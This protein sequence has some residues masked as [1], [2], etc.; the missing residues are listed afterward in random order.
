MAVIQSVTESVN[1]VACTIAEAEEPST[2]C[3][4]GLGERI[5]DVVEFDDL[6]Q[7]EIYGPTGLSRLG[8]T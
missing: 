7:T 5:I 4:R 3:H 8:E 2:A 1:R 6:Q